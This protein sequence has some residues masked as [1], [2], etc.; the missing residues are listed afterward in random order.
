[1]PNE[2]TELY[3]WTHAAFG[4][5][6]FTIADF[7]ENFPS[8]HPKKV[9]SDLR[10][11]GYIRSE[12]RGRYRTVSPAE[13]LDF[14]IERGDDSLDIPEAAGLPYAYSRETAV[15]IWTDGGYWTGFT[16]GFRP[17]HMEVPEE[18]TAFWLEYLKQSGARAVT[19]HERRTLFGVVHVLHPVARVR[20]SRR[21]GVSVVPIADTLAFAERRPYL[22]EPVIPMLRRKAAR[23]RA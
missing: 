12:S 9:L 3:A 5:R 21:H 20:A 17:F 14:M 1:M 22:Y 19:D 4:E 16:R 15:T 8:P 13:W 2:C 10:R 6:E 23:S 11:L 7:R 18:K